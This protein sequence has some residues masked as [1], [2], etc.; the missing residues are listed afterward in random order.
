MLFSQ[1]HW[2][3]VFLQIQQAPGPDFRKV[4]KY[5]EKYEKKSGN[6]FYLGLNFIKLIVRLN[7]KNICGSGYTLKK[8]RVG[9]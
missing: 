1:I 3:N 7:K 6:L 9:R 2:F 5:Q 4:G 8:I